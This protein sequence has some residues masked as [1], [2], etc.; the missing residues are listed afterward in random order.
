MQGLGYLFSDP[1]I[2]AVA[3]LV[4]VGAVAVRFAG[5]H[6]PDKRV[7]LL[8]GVWIAGF[9]ALSMWGMQ[10]DRNVRESGTQASA[11]APVGVSVKGSTHYVSEAQAFR[12]NAVLW[13]I[14][15]AGL[16]FALVEMLMLRRAQQD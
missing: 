11:E 6:A 7:R 9:L 8:R 5:P 10:Q 15:G 12:H 3:L 13:V 2:V 4:V 14:L 1:I 16:S